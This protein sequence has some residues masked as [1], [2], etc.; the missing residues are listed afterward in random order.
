MKKLHGLL[1]VTWV[2]EL[3]QEKCQT[4][5]LPTTQISLRYYEPDHGA[6]GKKRYVTDNDDIEEMKMLH[7]KTKRYC[8]SVIYFCCTII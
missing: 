5:K 7:N 1:A 3:I 6:K 4:L 8:Y 2:H